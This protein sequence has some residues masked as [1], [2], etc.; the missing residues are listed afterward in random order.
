MSCM[1]VSPYSLS[2]KKRGIA[3]HRVILMILLTVVS[4]SAMARWVEIGNNENYTTYVD[5]TTVRKAGNKVKMW[6]LFDYKVVFPSIEGRLTLSAKRQDE[7]DCK[8]VQS[9]VIDR[10]VH[11]ENMG[12]GE[13]V[14]AEHYMGNNPAGSGVGLFASIAQGSILETMWKYACEKR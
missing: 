6:S 2:H 7:F 13:V 1:L 10:S 11:S 14:Y 3:M 4:S 5:S 8:K 9:R 12:R